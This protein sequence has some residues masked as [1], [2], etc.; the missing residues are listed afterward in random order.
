MRHFSR[1][2]SE[3]VVLIW[4][5]KLLETIFSTIF[6]EFC[7]FMMPQILWHAFLDYLLT[8][9]SS[10]DSTKLMRRSYRLPSEIVVPI[11]CHKLYETL[12]GTTFWLFCTHLMPLIVWDTFL[13]YHLSLLSQ[14]DI[15][16][17]MRRFSRL[18]FEFVVHI[19]C[20]ILYETIFYTTFWVC[21]PHMMPQTIRDTF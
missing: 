17:W 20:H 9:L 7:P 11:W 18:R 1:L 3:F 16:H 12:F 2:P 13:D 19:W 6:W 15:E 14:F 5:H 10:Y 8:L 21:C 4:W